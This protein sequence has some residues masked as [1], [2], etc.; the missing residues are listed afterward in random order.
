MEKEAMRDEYEKQLE[1][2]RQGA[3]RAL[4][5]NNEQTMELK[6]KIAQL[7][8]KMDATICSGTNDLIKYQIQVQFSVII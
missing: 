3:V 1:N 7:T 8:A 4:D 5:S 2:M 6:M